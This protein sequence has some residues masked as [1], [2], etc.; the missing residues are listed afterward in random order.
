MKRF[1][2]LAVLS[3]SALPITL[4]PCSAFAQVATSTNITGVWQ[5]FATV[6]GTEQVPLT[7]RISGSGSSLKAVFLNG[8]ADHPDDPYFNEL[9]GD[10]L[11]RSGKIR[12]AVPAY[13]A[14]VRAKPDSPLL[15][16][17]LG[18]AQS[19]LQD[20]ASVKSSIKN[21][22][23]VVE[24]EPNN[25]GAWKLLGI[26][27]GLDHQE[28]EASLALAISRPLRNAAILPESASAPIG[29]G[30]QSNVSRVRAKT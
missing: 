25:P 26:A 7:L 16:M 15:H 20:P 12:E 1:A 9:K 18:R 21:L 8:P 30:F 2:C 3:L 11:Y 23:R 14:A 27:Y 4:V 29:T 5:G 17:S 13:E 28:A 6:R 24:I 10:I 22:Q 19:D